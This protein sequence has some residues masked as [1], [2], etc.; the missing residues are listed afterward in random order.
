[1]THKIEPDQEY[2]EGESAEWFFT[3][4]QDGQAK[5]LTG[6]SFEWYLL[7]S[8]GDDPSEAVLSSADTNVTVTV[9]DQANGEVRLV[10]EQDVTSGMGGSVYHHRLV[11]DD[12]GTGKQIWRGPFPIL[13]A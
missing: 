1:M 12:D 9:A 5:D 13:E 10:I 8:R 4:E 11:G 6:V 3:I 2:V 7:E